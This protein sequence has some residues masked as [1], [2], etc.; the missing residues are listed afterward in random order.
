MASRFIGRSL[1]R[2]SIVS[3]ENGAEH[4]RHLFVL[5]HQPGEKNSGVSVAELLS[6]HR[7]I[8][9]QL[10]N[11]GL[12]VGQQICGHLRGVRTFPGLFPQS[13]QLQELGRANVCVGEIDRDY[14]IRGA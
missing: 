4:P 13:R 10:A 2:P 5:I 8:R 14:R 3:L 12:L 1:I 7:H 11:H 6:T 9:A